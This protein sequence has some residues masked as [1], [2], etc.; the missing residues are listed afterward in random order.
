MNLE[1]G[2]LEQNSGATSQ[3]YVI[4]VQHGAR[5]YMGW[6]EYVGQ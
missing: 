2:S 1:A 3:T 5:F 6:G 4:E